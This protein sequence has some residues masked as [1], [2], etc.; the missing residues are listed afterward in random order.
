MG[1]VPVGS[2]ITFEVRTAGDAGDFMKISR[3]LMEIERTILGDLIHLIGVNWKVEIS[4]EISHEFT[5]KH[6][7]SQTSLFNGFKMI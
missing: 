1:D 7:Q 4:Q 2:E 6:D 3:D 5:I